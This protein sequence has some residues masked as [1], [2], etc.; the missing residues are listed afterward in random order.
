M[1][2]FLSGVSAVCC[3]R[4]GQGSGSIHL[5]DVACTGSEGTLLSCR[6]QAITQHNCGHSE[7]AAVRCPPSEILDQAIIMY[8]TCNACITYSEHHS[9]I[10]LISFACSHI[11]SVLPTLIGI[12]NTDHHS[13]ASDQYSTRPPLILPVYIQI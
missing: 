10:M 8:T 6:S 9:S 11:Y 5:D 1:N 4:Y 13:A 3:A 12:V 7:D 2:P